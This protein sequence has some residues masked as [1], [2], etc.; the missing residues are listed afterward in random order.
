MYSG[1]HIEIGTRIVEH[2]SAILHA[3]YAYVIVN[4]WGACI[5]RVTVL[6]L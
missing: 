3:T 2:Y 4:P 5:V 6:G 1:L